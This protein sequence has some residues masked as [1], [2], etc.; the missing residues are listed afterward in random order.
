MACRQTEYAHREKEKLIQQ[1]GGGCAICGAK[2]KLQVDHINRRDYDVRKLSFSARIARYK[3]EAAA[4][5]LRLLCEFHNLKE[6]K[7]NDHGA[8]VPTAA[9]IERTESIP[10]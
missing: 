7:T 5:L 10:F 8:H 6:R 9:V 2:T 4:G 3:R 1:L